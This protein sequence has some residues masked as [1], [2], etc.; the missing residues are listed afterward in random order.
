MSRHGITRAH[1]VRLD[2]AEPRAVGGEDHRALALVDRLELVRSGAVAAIGEHVAGQRHHADGARDGEDAEG[3]QA[4][5]CARRRAVDASS[6][7]AG[8]ELMRVAERPETLQEA[9]G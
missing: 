7:V 1:H 2:V 3:E 4:T 9:S 6:T 8:G 5:C